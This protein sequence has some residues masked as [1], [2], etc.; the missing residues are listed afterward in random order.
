[1]GLGLQLILKP[2]IEIKLGIKQQ[3]E[4]ILK[5]T[6]G[7]EGSIDGILQTEDALKT[8]LE[9]SYTQHENFWNES[10]MGENI[11]KNEMREAI[12]EHQNDILKLPS[13]PTGNP[14]FQNIA[15]TMAYYL[16]LKI[17]SL[18]PDQLLTDANSK[19]IL[20]EYLK[21]L[22]LNSYIVGFMKDKEYE[23]IDEEDRL[24]ELYSY[25][26]EKKEYQEI[27]GKNPFKSAI[28]N[29]EQIEK[30]MEY[31]HS[32]IK[33]NQDNIQT[34][35]EYTEM[36]RSLNE[37][38]HFRNKEEGQVHSLIEI[39]T[40]Y[41]EGLFKL[42]PHIQNLF[43]KEYVYQQLKF[44]ASDRLLRRFTS[45]V[46]RRRP[47]YNRNEGDYDLAFTNTIGEFILISMGVISE[48]IFTLNRF[49]ITEEET[50][51]IEDL[52]LKRQMQK[53]GL[54][55]SGNVFFNRFH[56][57][58]EKPSPETD[59]LVREFITQTVR[60]HQEEI[61]RQSEFHEFLPRCQEYYASLNKSEKENKE[62]LREVFKS[63]LLDLISKEEFQEYLANLISSQEFHHKIKELY[64]I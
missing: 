44:T 51:I 45:G 19:E 37:S 63:I 43:I 31:L 62:E 27:I 56:T 28:L 47:T 10:M 18:T 34:V 58:N 25:I 33:E 2:R 24:K 1:M 49:E 22:K 46:L 4:L 12:L 8:I 41:T 23:T 3:V 6:E 26:L 57:Q 60:S 20:T 64:N 50:Q 14:L 29:T 36:Q 42:S 59:Q 30:T 16:Y 54:K 32:L 5:I 13:N 39:M 15:V 52:N 21:H 11:Y 17:N 35:K 55:T 61:I 9:N 7:I 40:I 38:N 48:D 53:L